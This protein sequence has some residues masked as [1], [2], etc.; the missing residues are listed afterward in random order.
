[1]TTTLKKTTTR[2]AKVMAL[3]TPLV[4]MYNFEA[5]IQCEPMDSVRR[6]DLLQVLEL[7]LPAG[8]TRNGLTFLK[9]IDVATGDLALAEDEYVQAVKTCAETHLQPNELHTLKMKFD[10]SVIS[11]IDDPV[12]VPVIVEAPPP[13][14]VELPL[15]EA[16][17]DPSTPPPPM[18]QPPQ[19][20]LPEDDDIA[21]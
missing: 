10:S 5:V 7:S 19:P 2:T 13:P 15:P 12:P 4:P 3:L 8:W 18:Y 1:M 16:Q 17:I 6:E 9:K 20:E 21:P 14:T 11:L